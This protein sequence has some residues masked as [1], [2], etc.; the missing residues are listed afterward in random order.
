MLDI[1]PL[2]LHRPGSLCFRLGLVFIFNLSRNL[3]FKL[4]IHR[5]IRPKEQNAMCTN[6]SDDSIRDSG[7]KTVAIRGSTGGNAVWTINLEVGGDVVKFWVLCYFR[8]EQTMPVAV[9]LEKE[10][11]WIDRQL[12]VT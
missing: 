9:V 7:N 1:S 4:K 11:H 12:D 2:C 10:I 8:Y 3:R 5:C 6:T